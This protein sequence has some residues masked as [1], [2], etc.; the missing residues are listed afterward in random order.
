MKNEIESPEGFI[1]RRQKHFKETLKEYK[2]TKLNKYLRWFPDINRKGKYG[3]LREAWTFMVQ[4]KLN[5]LIRRAG[6]EPESSVSRN[7]H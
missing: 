7:K 3:F 4:Y 2:K 6:L 5:F 1:N